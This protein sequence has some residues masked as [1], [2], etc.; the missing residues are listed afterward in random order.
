MESQKSPSPGQKSITARGGIIRKKEKK[1]WVS[2]NEQSHARD[3][4]SGSFGDIAFSA[5][6]FHFL[7]CFRFFSAA[8]CTP[9]LFV[10]SLARRRGGQHVG[11]WPYAWTRQSRSDV[12]VL[13]YGGQVPRSYTVR[14]WSDAVTRGMICNIRQPDM[15]ICLM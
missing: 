4:R 11:S 5:L 12:T 1:G 7:F 8:W 15:G 9:R 3:P 14:T 10:N 6:F 13:R 2:R